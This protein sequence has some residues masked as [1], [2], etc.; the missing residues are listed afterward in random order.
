MQDHALRGEGF[1][2]ACRVPMAP[3]LLLEKQVAVWYCPRGVYDP[4]LLSRGKGESHKASLVS[5]FCCFVVIAGR[6]KK[7]TPNF[8]QFCAVLQVPER[9]CVSVQGW[10]E[11]GSAL[12]LLL[13]C[14]PF[15]PTW[16]YFCL[17]V[18]GDAVK[19]VWVSK[20]NFVYMKEFLSPTS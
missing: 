13:P 10:S 7:Q 20:V 1:F 11:Q 5:L 3:H 19:R 18:Q 8:F 16:D 12:G 15:T 9:K 14:F 17:Q 6:I 4:R 2:T